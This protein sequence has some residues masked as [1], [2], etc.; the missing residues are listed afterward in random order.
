MVG[1]GVADVGSLFLRLWASI[2]ESCQ[3]RGR[4]CSESLVCIPTWKNVMFGAL[5]EDKVGKMCTGLRHEASMHGA[6]HKLHRQ[7]GPNS[8][9][10]G[11][12]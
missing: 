12:W 1:P 5:L 11:A 9:G 2:W 4:D 6:L 8:V 7:E 3:Q 10:K